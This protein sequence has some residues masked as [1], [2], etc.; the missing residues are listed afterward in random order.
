MNE[1]TASPTPTPTYSPDRIAARMRRQFLTQLAGYYTISLPISHSSHFFFAIVPD[2]RRSRHFST[3][4]QRSELACE[5]RRRLASLGADA[6]R[7]L[8]L[9]GGD[10]VD[11][12]AFP[13]RDTA[14]VELELRG[15][16]APA[17]DVRGRHPV[18]LHG[19][20]GGRAA[21]GRV[22]EVV[23]G[24]RG[25][26][27]RRAH[28]EADPAAGVDGGADVGLVALGDGVRVLAPACAGG[29][30]GGGDREE[31]VP[32]RVGDGG[33]PVGLADLGG[34]P[35]RRRGRGERRRDGR[36]A[37]DAERR[38]VRQAPEEREQGGGRRRG[39]GSSG[40]RVVVVVVVA[41]AAVVEAR[42]ARE[43]G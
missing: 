42:R 24:R 7:E 26:R 2:G 31:G 1:T 18:Q 4:A 13:R 20:G 40:A 38:E 30:G 36:A 8:E 14:L 3:G 39:S 37:G 9:L 10:L 27:G 5:R 23:G 28:L 6:K 16:A 11:A 19:V 22:D 21:A 34:R 35:R 12:L 29:A 15:T 41:A 32:E 25:R 43:A 33:V 17:A